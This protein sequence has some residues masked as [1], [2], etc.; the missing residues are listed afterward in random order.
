MRGREGSPGRTGASMRRHVHGAMLTVLH[1]HMAAG[2]AAF[3]EPGQWRTL[4]VAVCSML[5]VLLS[6]G[7]LPP[8]FTQ[9][10][11]LV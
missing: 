6:R 8:S 5:P 10:C 3:Q 9:L 4:S 2:R 7:V 1:S 11:M